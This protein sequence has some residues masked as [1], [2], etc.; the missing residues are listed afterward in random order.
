MTDS[1]LVVGG[2]ITGL[3][4]ALE[5]AAAGAHAIVVERDAVV[6]GRLAAALTQK[7]SVGDHIDGVAVP[8]LEALAANEK[9]EILTLAD[10]VE[11]QGNPGN[12]DVSIRER[13]RF[14]TDACTRCN[15]CKPVC[16]VIR[17]NEHDAG[18]TYRK[19]IYTPLSETLPKDFV[20]DIDACLNTPP[21]YLPCNR[22][23]EVCDDDAIHFDMLAERPHQRRVGA[24]VI[25][26]GFDI[27]ADDGGRERGYGSHPDVV[28]TAEMERLLMAPGPTGGFAAKPSNE[29]YPH[30]ILLVLDDLTPFSVHTVASQVERLVAQDVGRI[31]VLVTHQPGS[32][33]DEL[34]A[35]LPAGLT[36][37]YGLLHRVE[38]R[39]DNKITVSFAD[40]TSS[41]MPE[42][43]YDM[44]VLSSDVR[45]PDG[46]DELAGILG[47]ELAD[48]GFVAVADADS[49]SATSRAGIYA[50]GGAQGPTALAEAVTAASAAAAAALSHLDPRLLDGDYAAALPTKSSASV[51]ETGEDELHA[52]IERALHAMLEKAG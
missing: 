15:H 35:V 45:P 21:N 10:V 27:V 6:G 43:T 18:L 49:P 9:I 16:P 48:N 29:D 12:F 37:N 17:P 23:T 31:A 5:C 22:C 11:L 3:T 7:S 14:V 1:I 4:A 8:K 33:Q 46:L 41:R 44:L 2:G 28:T 36:V 40:F 51:A 47:C 26:A 52:R 34:L 39:A 24:V 20:I 13:A 32:D 30:S 19:A 50:A 38:A 25:A 42:N